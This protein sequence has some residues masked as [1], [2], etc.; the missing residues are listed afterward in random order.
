MSAND[1]QNLKKLELIFRQTF[2]DDSLVLNP[3]TSPIDILDWDSLSHINLISAVEQEFGI[4]FGV[5]EISKIN[6]AQGFLDAIAR[7]SV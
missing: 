6:N 5:D 2:L 3:S 7:H 4:H 1:Y